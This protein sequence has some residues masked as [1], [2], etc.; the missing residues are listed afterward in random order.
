MQQKNIDNR[1]DPNFYARRALWR[2]PVDVI[3]NRVK[4]G[5]RR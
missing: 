2:R 1:L 3:E 5:E 4:L